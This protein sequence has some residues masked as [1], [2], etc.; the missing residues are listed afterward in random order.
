[1]D[2]RKL[3]NELREVLNLSEDISGKNMKSIASNYS[4]FREWFYQPRTSNESTFEVSKVARGEMDEPFKKV[5]KKL[6]AFE[7]RVLYPYFLEMRECVNSKIGKKKIK[8][9]EQQDQT[10]KIVQQEASVNEADGFAGW[11]AIFNGKKIEIKK[12]EA[13]DLYGAKQL[14]IQ[15]LNVPKSKVGLLAIEPAYD[16]IDED[17]DDTL[18]DI[19]SLTSNSKGKK[20]SK[21]VQDNTKYAKSLGY[22]G[23]KA[24]KVLDGKV[25]SHGSVDWTEFCDKLRNKNKK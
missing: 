14:A 7:N 16:D 23:D 15:K 18:S 21:D 12:D 13:K 25:V 3:R 6:K 11:I 10:N 9:E 24:V 4:N 17:T 19:A 22:D 20:F 1:M 2:K 5:Q 8:K